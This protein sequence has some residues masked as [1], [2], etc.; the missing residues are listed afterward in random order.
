MV[1]CSLYLD[2]HA[3]TQT[4]THT[5]THQLDIPNYQ[6]FSTMSCSVCFMRMV[7]LD[8]VFALSSRLCPIQLYRVC[9]KALMAERRFPVPPGTAP[10]LGV[11]P[12][13]CHNSGKTCKMTCFGFLG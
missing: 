2:M 1:T 6:G 8:V 5:C 10:L 9:T 4:H 3:H 7:T 11:L 12:S 13:K